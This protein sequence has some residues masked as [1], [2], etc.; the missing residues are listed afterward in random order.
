MSLQ[1]M[2]QL[3]EWRIVA[4]VLC[5]LSVLSFR[6]FLSAAEP[7]A[8]GL[9]LW[10]KADAVTGIATGSPLAAWP[11]S[12]GHNRAAAQAAAEQ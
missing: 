5:V 12:S 8:A 3:R 10:L 6:S 2:S 1:M 9:A 7:P 4:S 11:D